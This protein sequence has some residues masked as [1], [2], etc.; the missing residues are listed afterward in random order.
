MAMTKSE[1]AEMERLRNDLALARALRWPDYK[2]EHIDPAEA[3]RGIG[4]SDIVPAWSFNAY[5]LRVEHGCFSSLYHSTYDPTKTTTQ[6]Q[7]GPWFPTMRDAL[8]ALR[9]AKT[10]EFAKTLAQLDRQIEGAA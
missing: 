3:R 4:F 5:S 10:I 2:P 7:G 1:R 6:G 9:V 8:M